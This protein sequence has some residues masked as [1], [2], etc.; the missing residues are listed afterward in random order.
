MFRFILLTFG[1][2]LFVLILATLI[3]NPCKLNDRKEEKLN[4]RKEEKLKKV[5][6]PIM[7]PYSNSYFFVYP[8]T[9]E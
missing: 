6:L 7:V 9:T 1:I 2:W 5:C 3:V 8:C 4:D